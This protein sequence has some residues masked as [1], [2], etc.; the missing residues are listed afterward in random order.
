MPTPSEDTTSE[1]ATITVVTTEG[2]VYVA[3]PPEGERGQYAGRE[4]LVVIPEPSAAARRS[5][6]TPGDANEVARDRAAEQETYSDMSDTLEGLPR[7]PKGEQA[8]D[9]TTILEPSSP[10]AGSPDAPSDGDARLIR[11]MS[12]AAISPRC[13]GTPSPLYLHF[14][15]L[16]RDRQSSPASTTSF[17]RPG[18]KFRGTQQSDRQVY[19]VQVE[20]KDVDLAESFLCGYLRIQGMAGLIHF[21]ATDAHK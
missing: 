18:S 5:S 1:P 12:T 19:D 2:N 6:E 9:A 16:G 10:T 11:S 17:L 15:D 4:E 3:C 13:D 20:L 7:S 21:R 14:P 8:E